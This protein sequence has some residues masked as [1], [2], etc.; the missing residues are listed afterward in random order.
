MAFT[1]VETD[2][3]LIYAEARGHSELAWQIYGERLF[4]RIL[5]N[6]RNLCKR[7]AASSRFR[8]F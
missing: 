5:P 6:S 8:G 1:I 3:G 7:C 2:M 4:Q